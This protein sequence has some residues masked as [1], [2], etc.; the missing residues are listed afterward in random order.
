MKIKCW[1][2]HGLKTLHQKCSSDPSG[3]SHVVYGTVYHLFIAMCRLAMKA[4]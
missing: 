2:A 4:K 3:R 1:I